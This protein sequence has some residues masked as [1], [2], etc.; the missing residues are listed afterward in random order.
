M[1][2][3]LIKNWWM[4]ALRGVLAVLFGLAALLMP[5]ITVSVLVILFGAYALV[6]GIFALVAAATGA[7]AMR[8]RWWMLVIEG[9]AGIAVG[10]VTFLWPAITALTLV[11]LVAAWAIITGFLEIATAIRLRRH[12]QGEWL[13]ALTGVVSI[14]LGIVLAA[15]PG[16]SL[17]AWVWL[18]GAYALVFGILM[19]VLAYRLRKLGQ[20]QSP[21]MHTGQGTPHVGTP[22]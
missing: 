17:I 15:E 21:H 19:L 18:I 20:G 4:V 7:T 13:L 22:V 1:L 10:I 11:L 5:G 8:E 14:I 6:D 16:A 3:Q 2:E 9:I 12:I